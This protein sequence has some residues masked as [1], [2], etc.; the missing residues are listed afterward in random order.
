MSKQEHRY[1]QLNLH[2]IPDGI[3]LAAALLQRPEKRYETGLSC[4]VTEKPV[5]IFVTPLPCGAGKPHDTA[6]SG[7][8]ANVIPV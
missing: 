8:N 2:S 7:R 1:R 5:H 6:L 3:K 4:I